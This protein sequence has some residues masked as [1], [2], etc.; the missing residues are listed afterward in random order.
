ML[1][2]FVLYFLLSVHKTIDLWMMTLYPETM[3]STFINLYIY[4]YEYPSRFYTSSLFLQPPLFSFPQG[5]L[6]I[7]L[8][9]NIHEHLQETSCY[10]CLKPKVR[11]TKNTFSK[12]FV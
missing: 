12:P 4:I 11:L 9:Q 2:S 10:H 7:F 1:F 6:W 5:N 8:C 3:I